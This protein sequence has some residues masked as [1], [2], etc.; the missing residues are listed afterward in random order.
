MG[1][2]ANRRHF[3][4]CIWCTCV[5]PANHDSNALSK[6]ASFRAW[7]SCMWPEALLMIPR[8]V[9]DDDIGR[10]ADD[11]YRVSYDH[12][13][14]DRTN[15]PQCHQHTPVSTPPKS[16]SR[17]RPPARQIILATRS[18]SDSRNALSEYNRILLLVSSNSEKVITEIAALHVLQKLFVVRDDDELQVPLALSSLDDHVQA[19]G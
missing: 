5:G 11:V 6:P 7:Q 2:I 8:W 14:L 9:R 19:L 16:I 3:W 18:F 1:S 4:W 12:Q 13:S 15:R 10:R 17:G